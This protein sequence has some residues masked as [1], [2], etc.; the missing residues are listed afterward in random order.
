MLKLCPAILLLQHYRATENGRKRWSARLEGI[1]EASTTP[2]F[3]FTSPDLS[4]GFW[5]RFLDTVRIVA[6]MGASW[7]SGNL[8]DMTRCVRLVAASNG[9]VS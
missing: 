2:A 7:G 4:P 1:A 6:I 3:S 9:I 8:C 5:E